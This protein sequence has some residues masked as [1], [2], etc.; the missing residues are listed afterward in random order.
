[1]L[2]RFQTYSGLLF[3]D[4]TSFRGIP[5]KS[6]NTA[7]NILHLDFVSNRKLRITMQYSLL[8]S[9]YKLNEL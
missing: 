1:M 7:T 2:L 5:K 6:L 8:L 3:W 9:V 4:K